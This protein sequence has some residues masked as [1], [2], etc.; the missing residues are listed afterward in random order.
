M[1]KINVS[2]RISLEINEIIKTRAEKLGVSHSRI[3]RD[4]I[5]NSL[6]ENK[7]KIENSHLIRMMILENTMLTREM[8]MAFKNGENLYTEA[9]KNCSDFAKENNW[10]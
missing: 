5:E 8:V 7:Q 1:Q 2:T 3:L 10:K 6:K 4:I 9:I